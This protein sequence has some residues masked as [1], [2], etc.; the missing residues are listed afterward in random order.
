MP[1]ATYSFDQQ[2][3]FT[4][5]ERIAAASNFSPLDGA[6]AANCF[7]VAFN[8]SDSP[9]YDPALPTISFFLQAEL[10]VAGGAPQAFA[11][12][13]TAEGNIYNIVPGAEGNDDLRGNPDDGALHAV[14]INL[15][16]AVAQMAKWLATVDGTLGAAVLDLSKWS[17]TGAYIG[18]E[19]SGDSSITLDVAHPLV[20]RDDGQAATTGGQL[21]SIAGGV[22][23]SDPVLVDAAGITAAPS[24]TGP[25]GTGDT[26]TFTLAGTSALSQSG[27]TETL[28]LSDGGA[29]AYSGTD[30]DGDLLF[31][32]TVQAGQTAT[33]LKVT[34][35]A[36]NGSKVG[37][38]SGA[39]LDLTGVPSAA[40]A[41][42]GLVVA[43]SEPS[44]SNGVATIPGIDTAAAVHVTGNAYLAAHPTMLQG[45][46]P[47]C[48]AAGLNAL[49]G[50]GP[51]LL[52]VAD[53][54]G[55]VAVTDAAPSS[56][57]VIGDGSD[58]VYSGSANA[59]LIGGTGPDTVTAGAGNDTVALGTAANTIDL[60][61]GNSLVV[62]QGADL[63]NAGSGHD[64]IDVLGA[65]ATIDGGYGAS[66][67]RH[68]RQRRHQHDH[69]RQHRRHRHRRQRLGDQHQCLRRHHRPWRH[70]RHALQR[71]ERHPEIHRRRRQH[72]RHR[73]RSGRHGHAL[74]RQRHQ[75]G[76]RQHRPRQRLRRQRPRRGRRRQRHPR[77]RRRLRRQRL[78]GRLRQ[79]DPD[80]RHRRRHPRRRL[81]RQHHHRRR[82][83][84]H[85][86][87]RPLRRTHRHRHRPH[88]RE[89]R[90]R[91][92]PTA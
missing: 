9:D 40:G 26:I 87:F 53:D 80:R 42:T 72:H 48:A 3:T 7:T 61:S 86:L 30:A 28:L 46:V 83:Q 23:A 32:D 85:Q 70:R 17:L 91:S 71:A 65:G 54:L 41:D 2:V 16:G 64:T 78:L 10:G 58:L 81:R 90:A 92:P 50:T 73:R 77:R 24:R 4:A 36:L 55:T 11:T 89:L 22:N 63:I 59:T 5:D 25:L 12:Y 14:S 57:I 43:A 75:R 49:T 33:D 79:R 67:A 20:T 52:Y 88:H 47:A 39:T 35:F 38:P 19:S 18:I 8:R 1:S 29:A 37:D 68:R 56:V 82:R 13:G 84:Q 76:S 45:M 60:G 69:Q 51:K 74:R 27:G 6:S 62:S 21:V 31:T 66:H 44:F 15:S 34:G